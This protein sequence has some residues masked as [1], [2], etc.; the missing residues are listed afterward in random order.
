MPPLTVI[1]RGRKS[2]WR[3]F[4]QGQALYRALWEADSPDS[5]CPGCFALLRSE[6][7]GCSYLPI[8]T[9]QSDEILAAW[10]ARHRGGQDAAFD[11]LGYTALHKTE[12]RKLHCAPQNFDTCSRA[13]ALVTLSMVFLALEPGIAGLFTS[14]HILEIYGRMHPGLAEL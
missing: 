1:L 13:F 8:G 4:I 12:L 11:L 9:A 3:T 7:E 14:L 5:E 10:I 2:E 6:Q